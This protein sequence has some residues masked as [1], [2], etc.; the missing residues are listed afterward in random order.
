VTNIAMMTSR[1][2]LAGE[3]RLAGAVF[4]G[5]GNTYF[6]LDALRRSG[7]DRVLRQVVESGRP[8]YGG[9]AGAIV[10]GRD[11]DTARHADPNNTGTIDTTGL[12]LTLG[13]AIWCHYR[14][15]DAALVRSYVSETGNEVIALSERSGLVRDGNTMR[16]VGREPA[17][18]FGSGDE[19]I[20]G[21]DEL[22]PESEDHRR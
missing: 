2:R 15:D 9:S 5:G 17:M 6:L 12:D 8:V 4:I 16:V 3:L 19:R 13:Y 10:L 18:L 7:A 20:L 14:N 1:Q 11:I 22:V 21:L